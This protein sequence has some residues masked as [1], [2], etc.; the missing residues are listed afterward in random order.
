MATTVQTMASLTCEFI[1]FPLD[2]L[3][4]SADKHIINLQKAKGRWEVMFLV[5][6]F[7][8]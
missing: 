2:F 4:A 6:E 5:I 8:E 1:S 3:L 7:Q